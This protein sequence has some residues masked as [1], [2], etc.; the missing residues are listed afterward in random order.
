M[1]TLHLGHK[2]GV[3]VVLE[4]GLGLEAVLLLFLYALL[5]T[6]YCLSVGHQD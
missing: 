5:F 1:T 6:L 3:V 2:E 4:A